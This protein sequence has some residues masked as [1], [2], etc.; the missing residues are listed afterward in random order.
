MHPSSEVIAELLPSLRRAAARDGAGVLGSLLLH[1]LAVLLVIWAA[2]RSTPAPPPQ[3]TFPFVP[4]DLIR[5][6]AETQS[7][8]AEH[9]ALVPQQHAATPQDAASPRNA[10]VSP[11]G[12]KRAPDDALEAKLKALARLKMPDTPLK[13][14]AGEGVSNVDAASGAPGLT[15]TYSIRDYVLA[16]VLRRWVLDFAKVKDRP[17]VIPIRVVMTRD[18][19]IAS[20]EIVEQARAKTDARYR[21]VA[22]GARNA[23]LLSSPI[24][25]PPGD[26]P[27]E[28]RFTLRLDSRAAAR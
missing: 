27:K 25:L 10:A 17:L 6:G 11:T 28:M 21:D 12:T 9:K 20:A 4:V 2:V 3:T 14:L 22:I 23:T 7:P 8:P 18:G 15:A 5:L 19:I 16:Q 24:A 13:P 1:G 26:Y